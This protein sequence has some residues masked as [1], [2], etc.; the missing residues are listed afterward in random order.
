MEVAET[1]SRRGVD[2]AFGVSCADAA[3]SNNGNTNMK[4]IRSFLCFKKLILK[5]GRT[6]EWMFSDL[7]LHKRNVD[8]VENPRETVQKQMLG[9]AV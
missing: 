2:G 3:A 5:R 1:L 6:F 9:Q 4:V 7:Y 8:W